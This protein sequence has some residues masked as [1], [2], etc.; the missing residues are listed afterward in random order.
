M[1]SIVKPIAMVNY[2]QHLKELER[3]G[4][5]VWLWTQNVEDLAQ[6]LENLL[7]WWNEYLSM[8]IKANIQ[9]ILARQA[10]AL[11]LTSYGDIFQ[12]LKDDW[13]NINYIQ[14]ELILGTSIRDLIIR[15]FS[16]WWYLYPKRNA[17]HNRSNDI[18]LTN[19]AI[20]RV[21]ELADTLWVVV[22]NEKIRIIGEEI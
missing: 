5:L 19:R 1:T 20:L 10:D 17:T 2:I 16:D 6:N 12:S 21:E 14:N 15:S 3:Q 7:E 11:T 9:H 18:K 22:K 8:F 4:E 13:V